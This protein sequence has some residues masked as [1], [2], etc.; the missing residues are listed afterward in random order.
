MA[1][2]RLDIELRLLYTC[3]AIFKIPAAPVIRQL[4]ADAERP[5]PDVLPPRPEWKSFEWPE[6]GEVQGASA[7]L[8]LHP[9]PNHG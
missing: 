7:L 6:S 2:A 4:V 8:L 1:P 9:A 5:L 3:E